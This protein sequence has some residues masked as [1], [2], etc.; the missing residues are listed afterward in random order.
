M[1]FQ[2]IAFRNWYRFLYDLGANMAPFWLPKSSK[3]FPKIDP[4]MHQ[5]FV[6]LAPSWDP[7][8]GHVGHFF[9]SGGG[10]CEVLPSSLLRWCFLSVF[11]L[12]GPMVYPTPFWAPRSDGVPH[13]WLIFGPILVPTWRHLGPLWRKIL[14]ASRNPTSPS[15][16]RFFLC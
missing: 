7:S 12:Q 6:H 10:P 2:K 9:G 15:S 11:W 4:K 3:I 1:I 14:C 8:W 16:A 13:F 5:F